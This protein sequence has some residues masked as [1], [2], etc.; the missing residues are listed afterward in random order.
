LGIAELKF[1]RDN[2]NSGMKIAQAG[3]WHQYG[4][5]NDEAA[6]LRSARAVFSWE[7]GRNL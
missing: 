2:R 4:T 3:A 1:I 7:G 5:Q 6:L